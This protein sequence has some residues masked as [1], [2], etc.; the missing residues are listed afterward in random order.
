MC[1]AAYRIQGFSRPEAHYPLG[2]GSDDASLFNAGNAA[3][4]AQPEVYDL[5]LRSS[6]WRMCFGFAGTALSVSD[7]I[8]RD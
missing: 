5:T 7:P 8:D 2:G 4:A 3:N 6:P 1:G